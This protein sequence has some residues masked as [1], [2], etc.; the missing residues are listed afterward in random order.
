MDPWWSCGAQLLMAPERLQDEKS[1]AAI[2]S[3]KYTDTIHME[4]IDQ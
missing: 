1:H 2:V 3:G 4:L